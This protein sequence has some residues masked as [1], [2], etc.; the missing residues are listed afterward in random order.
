[1]LDLDVEVEFGFQVVMGV[2]FNL[3]VLYFGENVGDEQ[4]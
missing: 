4:I 2:D 1:M 3:I